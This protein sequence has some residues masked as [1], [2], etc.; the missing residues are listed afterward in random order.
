MDSVET[1][2]HAAVDKESPASIN[3][4]NLSDSSGTSACN[5]PKLPSDHSI[6]SIG[7]VSYGGVRE[8][9]RSKFQHLQ[10]LPL[11]EQVHE[12]KQ[13]FTIVRKQQCISGTK[14]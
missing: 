8:E 7:V 12:L 2:E 4:S 9:D 3:E 1:N 10:T 11:A 5:P 14:A 13:L 6:Y